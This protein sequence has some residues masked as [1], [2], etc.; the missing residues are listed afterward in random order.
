MSIDCLCDEPGCSINVFVKKQYCFIGSCL[1]T[2]E[3][4]E[5]DSRFTLIIPHDLLLDTGN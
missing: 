5:F 4:S 3:K 1:C 2:K